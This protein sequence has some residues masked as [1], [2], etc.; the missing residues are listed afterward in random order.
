MKR[1]EW[2]WQEILRNLGWRGVFGL[3][4]IAGAVFLRVAVTTPLSAH[5]EQLKMETPD[6]YRYMRD[7]IKREAAV[8]PAVQL[9][10]FYQHFNHDQPL[11]DWLG[12]I[13][14][15]GESHHL[16]LRQA[17]YRV[18]NERGSRLVQYQIALPVNAS[19]PQ[20]KQFIGAVL[21]EAPVVSLDQLSIQRRK[22]GDASVDAQLQ[23]TLFL[24]DKS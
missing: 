11:T 2:L 19:Y 24:G 9:A 4:L 18:A 14:G 21:S 5:I 10:A 17:E 1:I 16:L 15:I 8:S 22:V 23:F 6:A 13:Y 7:S 3:P 12:K 20:L